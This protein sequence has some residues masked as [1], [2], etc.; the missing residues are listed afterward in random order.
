[1]FEEAKVALKPPVELGK[2]KGVKIDKIDTEVTD[3]DIDKEIKREQEANARTITVEDRPVKEG[4]TA[5]I[6][7]EGFVDGEAFQGGKGDNYPLVIGSHSFIPGFED[8][9]IG[10]NAGLLSTYGPCG[11]LED[12]DRWVDEGWG[13]KEELAQTICPQNIRKQSPKQ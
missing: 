6:D 3:E 11:G 2:Y 1:M 5:V 8:Q 9:L 12:P 13:Q 4:D 10:K 7:F